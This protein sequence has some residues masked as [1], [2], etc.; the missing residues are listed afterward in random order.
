MKVR[1]LMNR[2]IIAVRRSTTLAE[3]VKF[4]NKFHTF[5]L[6]P[7]VEEEKLAGIVS[8]KNLAD[9][10][11]V[12][13]PE[14]LKTVPFIDQ[15]PENIMRADLSAEMGFLVIVD[16]I[17]STNFFSVKE[18]TSVE[19]AYQAMLRYSLDQLPV[20]DRQNKMTG[21]IGIFDIFLGILR[22]KGII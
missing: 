5:P 2:D 22:E 4:F 12:Q 14:I 10:F 7:V 21:I 19:D 9:I 17:M 16:D 8:F 1:D 3:L 6:V 15:E 13:E 18:E 11:R 20:V